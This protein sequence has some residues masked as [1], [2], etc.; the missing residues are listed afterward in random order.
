M[1]LVFDLMGY[2]VA[3]MGYDGSSVS[4]AKWQNLL[5]T[6]VVLQGRDLRMR[7]F[8]AL[9]RSTSLVSRPQA[10]PIIA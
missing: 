3:I 6:S 2:V 8:I 1:V 5:G 7:T 4:K 9:Q 10:V